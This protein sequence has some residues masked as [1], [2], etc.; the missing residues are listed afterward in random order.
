M[1]SMK[2]SS[3]TVFFIHVN[4]HFKY[5]LLSKALSSLSLSKCLMFK[6]TIAIFCVIKIHL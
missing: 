2:N 6:E 3:L 4:V 5:P 1:K